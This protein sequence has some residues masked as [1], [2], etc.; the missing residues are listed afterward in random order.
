MFGSKCRGVVRVRV[1]MAMVRGF[2]LD[3]DDAMR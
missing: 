3:D 1:V 2:V